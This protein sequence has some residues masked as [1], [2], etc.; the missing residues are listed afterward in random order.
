MC[1]LVI[2][3]HNS[4]CLII[5]FRA[6]HGKLDLK[7]LFLFVVPKYTSRWE[8]LGTLLGIP[9]GKLYAIEYENQT[10]ADDCCLKMLSNWLQCDNAASW[11]KVQ[12]AVDLLVSN[13]I[14]QSGVPSMVPTVKAF[15]KN[16]NI[17]KESVHFGLV[18]HTK[19]T[20]LKAQTRFIS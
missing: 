12:N 9:M 3:S 11:G 19:L 8:Q 7:D 10:S 5:D 18:Y 20:Q 17:Q 4:L 2:G 14:N 15:F 1:I 6:H 16:I 13:P